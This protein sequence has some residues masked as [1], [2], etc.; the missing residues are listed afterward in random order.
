MSTEEMKD[1]CKSAC[2]FSL[3]VQVRLKNG[4]EVFVGRVTG[5]EDERFQL[6]AEDQTVQQLRYAWVARLKNA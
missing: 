1:F 6:V 2:N 3:K 5:V 4:S